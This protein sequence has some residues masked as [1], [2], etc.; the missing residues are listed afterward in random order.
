[1]DFPED[2]KYTRE[3]EWARQK[4][5]R[6]VIGITDFAQDQLGDVVFVELPE[7]G[8]TVKKG[9]SFGVVES[10]KAVSELFAPISGKVVEVNDPLAD[11]PETINSDPYEE[12]WMIAVEPSDPKEVEALMDVRA[13]RAFVEEQ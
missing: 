4:G 7:I 9:E 5:S 3:H 8:D 10:T 11:A 13:Y 2:L 1:M 12:G 6:I